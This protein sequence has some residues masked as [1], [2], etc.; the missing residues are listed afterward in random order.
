MK[1]SSVLPYGK[2]VKKE[3]HFTPINM[4]QSNLNS[5][6]FVERN[7]TLSVAVDTPT[8]PQIQCILFVHRTIKII[9]HVTDGK[10]RKYHKKFCNLMHRKHR[11]ISPSIIGFL[12][13]LKE[14]LW[15]EGISN[16]LNDLCRTTAHIF[17]I[18]NIGGSNQWLH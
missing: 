8:Y 6:F 15:V 9:A 10:C 18:V 1:H 7:L 17:S 2:K 3:I 5:K 13:F 16:D 4:I 11:C 14:V 12:C